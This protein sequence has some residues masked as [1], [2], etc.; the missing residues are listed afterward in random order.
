[1]LAGITQ[2]AARA[3]GLTDRGML[4]TG[5]RAD[6]VAFPTHDYREILYQQGS[7]AASQVWCEG[8]L[9]KSEG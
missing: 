3:L 9:V 7:L 8:G 5:Y 6:L 1:M 4:A 2:R